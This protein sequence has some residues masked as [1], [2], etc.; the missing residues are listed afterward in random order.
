MIYT[1]KVMD[2]FRN[3]R[4][5]GEIEDANGIGEVDGSLPISSQNTNNTIAYRTATGTVRASNATDSMDLVPLG[6]VTAMLDD[7]F[8]IEI[9]ESGD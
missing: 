3:P 4:N 8:N 5:V 6:Q 9:W 1:D 2:H 7:M